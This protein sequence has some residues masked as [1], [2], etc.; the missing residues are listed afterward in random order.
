LAYH[1]LLY[2]ELTYGVEKSQHKEKNEIALAKFISSLIV[3][4]FDEKSAI[5]YGQVRASLEKKGIPIGPMDLL[6]A[7]HAKSLNI[8][9][10]THNTKEFSRVKGLHL[11]N[12]VQDD[13]EIT[14]H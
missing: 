4:P 9:L 10:V 11:E 8:V 13:P 5:S 3:L 7:A 6:I 12:W 14:H 1:L 2:S